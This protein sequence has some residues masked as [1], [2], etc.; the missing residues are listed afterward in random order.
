MNLNDL[1]MSLKAAMDNMWARIDAR[2]HAIEEGGGT[3]GPQGPPGPKGDPGAAAGFGTPTA[4]VD[5]NTGT[6]SVTVTASGPDTAKV[7]AFAF[8]N[9]KGAT[10]ATGPQGPQGPQGDPATNLITGVKGNAESSYRQGNVNLTP[11]NIGAVNKAGDTMTGP[12]TMDS[13]LFGALGSTGFRIGVYPGALSYM[14]TDDDFYGSG[15]G[16]GHFIICNH[17]NGETD[18]NYMLRLPFWDSPKYKRQMGSTSAQTPWYD[19]LTSEKTVTVL[20]GGTGMTG[21]TQINYTSP[22]WDN[23]ARVRVY[24]WGMICVANIAGY[25]STD[26][27][28][29]VTPILSIGDSNYF[30][31]NYVSSTFI[32]LD[33]T[34]FLAQLDPNGQIKAPFKNISKDTWIYGQIV[35]LRGV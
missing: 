33:G 5:A 26:I 1:R 21:C 30:P 32:M 23:V 28:A 34:P 17:L 20:Q 19:F 10:G 25:A 14:A 15:G 7:F 22:I 18:Y 16:W 31:G 11:A 24:S 4:T 2:I 8:S 27:T 12:L 29:D 13:S 9:L 6:P 35:W 3:P